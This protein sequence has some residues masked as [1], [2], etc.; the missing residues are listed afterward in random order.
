MREQQTLHIPEPEAFQDRGWE[1]LCGP[2]THVLL[3]GGARSGKTY[4]IV[5][6]I[7]SRAL[8][9]PEATQAILRLRFNH[10]KASIIYDTLPHVM[11]HEFP[12]I[13]WSL[14]KSDWF[15]R[16]NSTK[17]SVE[18][19][20]LYFGGLDDKERTEKILGQGHSTIYLNEASQL[21]YASRLKAITRL[22]Q[23]RGLRLKEIIDENPPIQGHW[24]HRLFVK[25]IE[26]TTG[27]AIPADELSDY[28]CAFMNPAE[29]PHIPEA[30]KR[31]L[32]ALPP[33]ERARFW[34]GKFGDAIDG[35]LWTYE[36]IELARTDEA[37]RAVLVRLVRVVVA[38][39]PSGCHGPEEKRSDEV[40][41]VVVGIDDQGVCYVLE[42][43]SGRHGPGG[44]DGWGALA[45]RLFHRYHADCVVAETNF[46]G[47]MVGAVV[48]AAE[49]GEDVPFRELH[50]TRG[51]SVRA[52]PVATRFDRGRVRLC[53]TFPEMEQQMLQFSTNGYGGDRSPDRTDAMVWG[54]IELAGIQVPGLGLLDFYRQENA[55]EAERARQPDAPKQTNGGPPLEGDDEKDPVVPDFVALNAPAGMSGTVYSRLGTAYTVSDGRVMARQSDVEDLLAIGFRRPTP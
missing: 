34:E 12:H 30:T 29:N 17:D 19:G 35:P 37:V 16:I 43:A 49:G 15:V 51:K 1:A 53:G 23:D 39:D 6:G 7:V 52:D 5:K 28:A 32:R 40:G 22:S 26:P 33:R 42:D 21:S 38:I 31:I 14:N 24:T 13:P 2:A 4:L 36:S 3:A 8:M 9:A 44:R 54:V 20:T 41:V 50:A 10:L 45:V 11:R 48:R 46:G 18:R 25:G 55:A 27:K 47:A